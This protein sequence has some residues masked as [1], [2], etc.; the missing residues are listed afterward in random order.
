MSKLKC[1]NC[2]SSNLVV[3]VE[4]L[5]YINTDEHYC[6]SVKHQDQNAKCRCLDCEWDGERKNL[7]KIGDSDE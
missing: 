2:E 4:T 7:L 6:H 3:R 5:F 1:P